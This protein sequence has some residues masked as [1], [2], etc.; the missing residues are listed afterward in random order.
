VDGLPGRIL[1]QAHKRVQ[2]GDLDGAAEAYI[3][4]LNATPE[5]DTKER[6]EGRK[7]LQDNFNIRWV[8]SS[9]S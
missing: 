3:L 1:E 6:S 8:T 4:Y 2:D 5:G 9:A 7:F